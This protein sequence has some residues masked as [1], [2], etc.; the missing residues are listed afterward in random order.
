MGIN[1]ECT[2]VRY[3]KAEI[4]V[5]RLQNAKDNTM[6]TIVN[7]INRMHNKWTILSN[8]KIYKIGGIAL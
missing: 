8:S 6:R 4:Q 7:H 3:E 2:Q 1:N 5:S